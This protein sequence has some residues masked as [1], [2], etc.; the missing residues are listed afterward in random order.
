MAIHRDEESM[1]WGEH[2]AARH[3]SS[4]GKQREMDVATQLTSL[5]LGTTHSGIDLPTSLNP[6]WETTQERLSPV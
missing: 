4:D 2:E 6:V 1:G 3:I 5:F